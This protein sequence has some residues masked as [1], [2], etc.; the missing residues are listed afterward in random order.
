[1][2][3]NL[4][5]KPFINKK[6]KQSVNRKMI[7]KEVMNCYKNIAFS[8]FPYINNLYTSKESI[9]YTNS[10]N[11]IG[12]SIY[13]KELLKK[14]YNIISYLIPATVPSYVMKEGYLDICHVALAIP[15][16]ANNYFII[17]PAF[18]FLE[19]IKVN[20]LTKKTNNVKSVEIDGFTDI[21]IVK[22]SLKKTDSKLVL[23]KYQ[24]IPKNTF[25]CECYSQ[26]EIT[27]TWK[28]FLREVINPDKSISK[29]FIKIRNNPF[30]VST[31]VQN[32]VCVK[33]ISIRTLSNNNI[34]IQIGNQIIYSGSKFDI[35]LNIKNYVINLLQQRNFDASI[36]LQ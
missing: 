11:C 17:D 14:K 15:I 6:V 25:Y 5:T 16:D 24:S 28:Y 2:Y 36:M 3:N 12:L 26:K 22:T 31:N 21:Q 18:Y 7:I 9:K 19:P 29:F 8:T 32:S 27:D 23:N 13:I 30:F 33:E 20:L 34:T 4:I 1:M 10:G 35:P